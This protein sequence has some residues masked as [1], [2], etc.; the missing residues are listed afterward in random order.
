MNNRKSSS[1]SSVL[2]KNVTFLLPIRNG[3]KWV[4]GILSNIVAMSQSGD[5]IIAIDDGSTDKT[6]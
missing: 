4:L 5:E 1:G 3:E 2:R 6:L